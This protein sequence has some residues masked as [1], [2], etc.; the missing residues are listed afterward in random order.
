MI[1]QRS[2]SSSFSSQSKKYFG[3]LK[4]FCL[5]HSPKYNNPSHFSHKCYQLGDTRL[6]LKPYFQ[7][8]EFS[9]FTHVFQGQFL[10]S[11][12]SI[13]KNQERFLFQ[14]E[15]NTKISFIFSKYIMD[16]K[17]KALSQDL[18]FRGRNRNNLLK[19][20]FHHFSQ[21]ILKEYL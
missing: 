16:E 6:S 12:R 3:I 11:K 14:E 9:C 7:K 5:H 8:T 19:Q 2:T 21:K 15:W 1:V 13:S 20:S 17:I 4:E 18:S 10:D